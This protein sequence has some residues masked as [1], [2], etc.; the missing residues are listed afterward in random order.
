VKAKDTNKMTDIDLAVI[1]NS[2]NRLSLLKGSLPSLYDVLSKSNINYSIIIFDANSDDGSREWINNFISERRT[3]NVLLIGPE[4]N[5]PDSFSFGVN[6]ACTYAMNKYP[7]IKYLFLYETDNFISSVEPLIHAQRLL[8]EHKDVGACGFTVKKHDGENA[9][10]GSSFPTLISLVL[11]QQLSFIFKSHS[12]DLKWLSKAYGSYAYVDVVYTS[13]LLIK[14]EVWQKVKGFD[15]VNFPFSDSDVDLAYRM[16]EEGMKMTVLKSSSVIH[17]N[18]LN[19]SFWSQTRTINF[20]RA[21]LTYFK[22]HFGKW[23]NLLKPFLFL[24]HL[25]ELFILFVLFI[26]GKRKIQALKIRLILIK[27]VFVDYKL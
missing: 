25:L 10:Y 8:E 23:I 6:S 12:S 3:V 24:T 22:K 19:P 13:P 17:D 9:G 27:S 15:L 16:R 1:I 7:E 18:L 20:Y 14:R 4:K 26:L 11:G 2:F 5:G 21:R